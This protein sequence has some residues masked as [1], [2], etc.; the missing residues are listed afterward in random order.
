[1]PRK[2]L[3]E[4][5]IGTLRGRPA[6][7]GSS[8]PLIYFDAAMP[9][10]GVSVSSKTGLKTYVVQR[11]LPDGRT[12]RRTIGLVGTE[13]TSLAEARE[14]AGEIIQNLRQGIDPRTTAR[15]EATLAMV[16]EAYVNARPNLSEKSK[17][18]YASAFDDYLSDWHDRKLTAITREMVE[19]RHLELGRERGQAIANAV[20]RAL[21]AI[22]NWAIDRYPDVTANPVK[23]RGQ[24]F[25]IPRRSRHVSADNASKFY[26]AVLE[27]PNDVAR[28]Y[29]ITLLFTGLR[30]EEAAGLTWGEVDC[31]AKV[32]RVPASRTKARRA[33]NLPMSDLIYRLLKDRREIGDAGY[34]F[35]AASTSGHIAEPKHPL[36]LIA[37]ATGIAISAHDL[38]R[39]WTNAAVEA[40]IHPLHMKAL[41]N[42]SLQGDVTAGYTTL[43]END[44][45]EPAQKVTD[46]LKKWCNCRVGRG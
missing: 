25:K 12:V 30:R 28:D 9:G 2:R 26:K 41:L 35:P 23:L 22:F 21:R 42:H 38:R 33:L 4:R 27:L 14:R 29:L 31:G 8:Q 3:T 44:L 32:I 24:W 34:V 36:G 40:G 45:R 39:T 46:Q 19:Q 18:G 37:E 15:G 43:T 20:M 1:M 16:A 17:A 5:V 13:I 6:G 10:F 11:D 7:S